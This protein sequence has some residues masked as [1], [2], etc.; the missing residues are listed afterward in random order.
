[1]GLGDVTVVRDGDS[2][3]M[4]GTGGGAWVSRDLVD[5]KYQAVEVQGGR[6]PV[7]PHVFKYNGALYLSGNDAPLYK[8]AN[9]LGPY[10]LLGPW[11]NERASPGQLP[12]MENGGRRIRRGRFHGRR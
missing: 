8:A 12:S 6:F 10:E 3:Y 1:M 4:F 9:I 5:W 7:A 2:Y 11:I